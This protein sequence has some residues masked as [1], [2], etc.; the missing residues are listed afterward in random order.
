MRK[1]FTIIAIIASALSILFAVLPISNLAI[2]PS[3]AAIISGM[4][5][6]YLSKKKGEVKKIIQ[7]TFLLTIAA[8]SI[9]AYKAIFIK[10]EVTN[11]EVLDAKETQFEEEAIEELEGLDIEDLEINQTEIEDIDPIEI[12]SIEIEN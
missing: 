6:Y 3:I 4:I 11:T 9:T 8:L 2:F 5:A 12:E 10:T 7:F 1:L